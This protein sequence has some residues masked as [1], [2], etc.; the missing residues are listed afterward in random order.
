MKKIKCFISFILI[1]LLALQMQGQVNMPIRKIAGTD[2]YYYKVSAKETIF[3]ISKKLNI[4]QDEMLKYNPSLIDGLKKDAVLFFPVELFSN[5]TEQKNIVAHQPK[6]TAFTHVVEKGETLYG[7]AKM[8]NVTP[9]DISA[10]NPGTANGIKTGQVL[11]IP[12]PALSNSDVAKSETSNQNIGDAAKEP[13]KAPTTTIYHTIKKGETLFSLSN[14]FNTTIEKILE[15]N[16]G[17][18][19]TNFKINEVIKIATNTRQTVEQEKTITQF[20]YYEVKKGDTFYSVAKSNNLSAEELEAANPNIDKLKKGKTIQIPV[21]KKEKVLVK[22]TE[23]TQAELADNDSP[24]INQIYQNVHSK[25]SPNEL[26]VGL[27]LPYMLKSTNPSKA[28]K[29]YTE[30]YKGFLIAV[31]EVRKTQNKKINIFTYDTEGSQKVLENILAKPEMKKLDLIFAPNEDDQIDR[32]CKFGKENNI[33][34][35]NN[36]SLKNEDYSVNPKIFQVNIPPSFFYA[37]VLEWMKSEFKDYDIVYLEENNGDIKDFAQEMKDQLPAT[38]GKRFHV[39]KYDQLLPYDDVDAI[40]EPGKKYLFVPSSATKVSL[41]Y[42]IPSLKK[43]KE[44]RVDIDT[45][46]FGYPE[47]GTYLSSYRNDLQTLDTYFYTRFFI[48]EEDGDYKAFEK[49]YKDWYNE[50]MINAMPSFGTLGYDSGKFFL[51]SLLKNKDFNNGGIIYNGL[52]NDFNFERINNWSGF[53]NKAVYFVH[54]SPNS[55]IE[56]I[57]R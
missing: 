16:P 46:L 35:I 27:L 9:E 40:L 43:V 15:L 17:V 49:L 26:N 32:I 8:Y 39:L 53:V 6:P 37:E 19:P 50:D 34:V 25:N 45:S 21:V 2:Y 11:S 51:E 57:A 4:T 56:K 44:E 31:D 12:Q 29:L 23:G 5:K 10:K 24:K 55:L 52:Q 20:E 47:W 54:L 30:F 38:F 48:N 13:V 28:A 42:I 7:I 1:M 41:A 14:Q 22:E 3:G 36:F 18:S 33:N